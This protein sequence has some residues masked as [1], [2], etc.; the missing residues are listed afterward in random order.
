M[1]PLL[2][3]DW[4]LPC[5]SRL[6]RVLAPDPSPLP[7]LIFPYGSQ[8]E[9]WK[10]KRLKES[11]LCTALAFLHKC[12]GVTLLA[13]QTSLARIC[14]LGSSVLYWMHPGPQ[15]NAGMRENRGWPAE[16]PNRQAARLAV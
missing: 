9:R 5:R 16:S 7:G 14:W 8:Q 13:P 12:T 4:P 2:E 1:K 15:N 10:W 6:P 11:M 3:Q